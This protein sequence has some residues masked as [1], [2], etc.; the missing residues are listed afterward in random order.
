MTLSNTR[1]VQFSF[2]RN[3]KSILNEFLLSEHE[4]ELE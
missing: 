2:Y 3:N 4:L 1:F